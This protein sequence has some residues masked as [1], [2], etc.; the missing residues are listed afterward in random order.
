[1]SEATIKWHYLPA[2]RDLVERVRATKEEHN[3]SVSV[4]VHWGIEAR[5]CKLEA[6]LQD[7]K[8]NLH[9]LVAEK[10]CSCGLVLEDLGM[11]TILDLVLSQHHRNPT[12]LEPESKPNFRGLVGKR[13]FGLGSKVPIDVMWD[14]FVVQHVGTMLKGNRVVPLSWT[15]VGD[16]LDTLLQQRTGGNNA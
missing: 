1:M 16:D 12:T 3:K 5:K 8:E 10:T 7:Q 9:S 4:V 6:L 2:E 11:T 14:N 15:I 13:H